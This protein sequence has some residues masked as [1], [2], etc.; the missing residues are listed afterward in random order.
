MLGLAVAEAGREGSGAGWRAGARREG[1]GVSTGRDGAAKRERGLA[2][3]GV[4][5]EER[6]AK[7]GALEG[8]V[9]AGAFPNQ[10]HENK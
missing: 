7:A 9:A 3:P 4:R 8:P 10:E 5:R 2:V 1:A 6:R